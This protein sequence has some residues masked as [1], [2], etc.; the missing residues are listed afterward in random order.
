MISSSPVERM[1]TLLRFLTLAFMLVQQCHAVFEA[2]KAADQVVALHK[3]N[4][5]LA[6]EDPA[7]S[8]WL[9]KFY[10]PW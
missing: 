3:G 5:K 8:F 10:A 7:N 6:M 2:G 9:L 4:F 1:M